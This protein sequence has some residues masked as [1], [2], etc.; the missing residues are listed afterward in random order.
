MKTS[1][2]LLR[3]ASPGGQSMN[4]LAVQGF[5]KSLTNPSINKKGITYAKLDQSAKMKGQ[6]G[7]K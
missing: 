5:R 7:I 4:V 2:V 6:A 3:T 1:P